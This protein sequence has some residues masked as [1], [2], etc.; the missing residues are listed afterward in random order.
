MKRLMCLA[1]LASSSACGI[2]LDIDRDGFACEAGGPCDDA[3]KPPREPLAP[4]GETVCDEELSLYS[5]TIRFGVDVIGIYKPADAGL[6]Q[7]R[8]ERPGDI[9]TLVIVAYEGTTWDVTIA[10]DTFLAGVFLHAYEPQIVNAP[11]AQAVD[12]QA[13]SAGGNPTLTRAYQ[14]G[15]TES[16][17][18]RAEI[19]SMF[20]EPVRSFHGCYRAEAF[21]IR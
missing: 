9:A 15:T 10:E 18:L 13:Y 11:D 5:D 2:D 3:P 12:V 16:E 19:E 21:V 7:V 6:V 8:I 20:G 1:V 14:W 17:Q 4:P